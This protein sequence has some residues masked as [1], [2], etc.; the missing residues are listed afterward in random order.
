M[1]EREEGD[2]KEKGVG[3]E[4]DGQTKRQQANWAER[5]KNRHTDK[6]TER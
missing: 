1:R 2:G 5:E 3:T 4:T 6:E